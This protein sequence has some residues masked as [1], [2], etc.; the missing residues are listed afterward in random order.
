MHE[1]WKIH[2]QLNL[3]DKIDEEKIK[4]LQQELQDEILKNGQE[5]KLFHSS[6]KKE[7]DAYQKCLK[8]L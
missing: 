1:L 4:I 6:V 3:S 2:S 7:I 5:G 8:N